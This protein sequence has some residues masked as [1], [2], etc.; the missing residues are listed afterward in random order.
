MYRRQLAAGAAV[1]AVGLMLALP[2]EGQAQ[3]RGRGFVGGS[4][5]YDG[6]SGYNPFAGNYS[7]YNPLGGSYYSG[8]NQGLTYGAYPGSYNQGMTYGAYPGYY[9]QGTTYGTAPGYYNQGMVSGYPYGS[10]G[11]NQYQPGVMQAG[12]VVGGQSGVM[13]SLYAPGTGSSSMSP[14]WVRVVL[15]TADAQVT[16]ENTPTRQTGTVRQFVSPPLEAGKSYEYTIRA[17]WQQDGQAKDD[18]RT[19]TVQA[20]GQS[21]ADFTSGQG[22]TPTTN[23][24]GGT[25]PPRGTTTLPSK[26]RPGGTTDTPPTNP[27]PGSPDQP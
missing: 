19:V 24:P 7:G 8:Y 21:V 2:G 14:A 4:P 5:G 20:G 12:G 6:F 25:N 27:R 18:T 22:G 26:D 17:Q 23:P 15:P 10:A 11:V 13:Q 16:I 9:N 1:L 3:R